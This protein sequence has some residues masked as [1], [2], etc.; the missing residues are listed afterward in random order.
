MQQ[1]QHSPGPQPGPQP[2]TAA[3]A[4]HLQVESNAAEPAIQPHH[5]GP[6]LGVEGLEAI[7][8][9]VP[10][11]VRQL[12]HQRLPDAGVLAE[13]PQV[14]RA[15]PQ[16]ELLA[17]VHIVAQ[18]THGADAHLRRG[19]CRSDVMNSVGRVAAGHTAASQV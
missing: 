3:Q 8:V 9:L 13:A 1:S 16:A 18:H 5:P 6:H 17:A 7:I 19:Q 4:H 15:Q 2:T 12:V 10:H 11:H 14:V